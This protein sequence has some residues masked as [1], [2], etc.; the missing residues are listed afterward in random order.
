ME[1]QDHCTMFAKNITLRIALGGMLLLYGVAKFKMGISGF[2]EEMSGMFDAT[3][4]PLGLA[5]A[6][7]TVVPLLEVVLGALILIGLY[8]RYAALTAALLFALFIVGLTSTGNNDF[9]LMMAANY[10]Y[11]FAAFKLSCNA[12]STWSLDHALCKGGKCDI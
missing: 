2:A 6:F 1:N 10:I 8:T 11:I 3:V 4:I 7:L 5:K 9:L 12:H